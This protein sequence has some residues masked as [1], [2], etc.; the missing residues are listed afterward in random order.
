[1]GI[2][3]IKWQILLTR[4]KELRV[5][6]AKSAKMMEND[7]DSKIRGIEWI[8]EIKFFII[9]QYQAYIPDIN[10]DF[11]SYCFLCKSSS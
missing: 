5:I 4:R 8:K 1:M 2:A 7:C 11:I 3:N 10:F 6:F 9:R